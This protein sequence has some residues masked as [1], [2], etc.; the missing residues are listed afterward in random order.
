[1]IYLIGCDHCKTQTSPGF[2]W[3]DNHKEFAALVL[4][5]IQKYNIIL[6]AEEENQYYLDLFGRR[7]V[8]LDVLNNLRN[9]E[10]DR[11][12]K[13]RFCDPCP[14]QRK[15]LGIDEDLPHI[16]PVC[17]NSKLINLMPT[18]FDS[19]LHEIGHRWPIREK[20]WIERLGDDIDWNVLFICGVFHICTFGSQLRSRSIDAK[21]LHRFFG[22]KKGQVKALSCSEEFAAYKEVAR[23]GF[24]L[25]VGCPCVKP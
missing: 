12:V 19:Y 11:D 25:G 15:L 24:P 7:S 23:N 20:F 13:H 6:I 4:N 8:A 1:M 2:A 18:R 22:H 17:F 14:S 16:N 3:D 10:M 5:V 21:V 9:I